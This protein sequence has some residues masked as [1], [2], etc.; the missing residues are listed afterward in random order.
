MG[1][2]LSTLRKQNAPFKTHVPAKDSP[3]P[4]VES[5]EEQ[6][7]AG[8]SDMECRA[9]FVALSAGTQHRL[10]RLPT[11]AEFIRLVDGVAIGRQL[12]AIEKD[13][14]RGG[15]EIHWTGSDWIFEVPESL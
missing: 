13:S 3:E 7:P 1:V 12:A 6:T 8:L 4:K 5:V 2:E 11:V 9:L 15:L 10:G 14:L